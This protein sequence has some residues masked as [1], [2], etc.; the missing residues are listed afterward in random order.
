MIYIFQC[1]VQICHNKYC[2]ATLIIYIT[3]YYDGDG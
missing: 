2:Y 1:A 3:V